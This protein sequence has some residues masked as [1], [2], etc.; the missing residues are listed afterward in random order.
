MAI[1][2]TAAAIAAMVGSGVV[3]LLLVDQ[4][5][6]HRTRQIQAD[7]ARREQERRAQLDA[8]LRIALPD[9]VITAEFGRRTLRA[10]Q[11]RRP[12]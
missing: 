11:S 10:G 1:L 2:H 4:W 9:R 8:A 12:L 7:A 3:F 5:W 6:A